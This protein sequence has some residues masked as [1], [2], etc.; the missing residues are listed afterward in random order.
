MVRAAKYEHGRVTELMVD[1]HYGFI[2]QPKGPLDSQ[3][4]WVW[5]CPS[6][7][8]VLSAS[9]PR[10]IVAHRFYVESL[11]ARG[12]CVGG[13]DV[14]ISCG[15]PAAVKVCT[16]FYQAVM[17][18]Y[19]L[20][21]RVRMIGQ[22]NGGLIAYAWAFRHP[23]SVDRILGIY[24][25]T[26]MR[27]WPG[28]DRVDPQTE[29]TAPD[30]SWHI[31]VPELR[32]RLKEFNPIDNLKP[33]AEA[34]VVLLHLHGD[35]DRGVPMGP[36][37]EEVV[38]RYQAMGGEAGLIVFEGRGHGPTGGPQFHDEVF[39]NS[40]RA[41]QFLLDLCCRF[42]SRPADPGRHLR[43]FVKPSIHKPCSRFPQ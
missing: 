42:E 27:T 14:G 38:K 10:G 7:Y 4:R 26:D 39:Y 5:D 22:S 16:D 43:V 33:L 35:S 8:A 20:N 15:S 34:G 12:F 37:S 9:P 24:P 11:L 41:L 17:S 2:I 1:G 25:V 18:K 40:E 21:Q 3:R 19:H 6:W 31:T 23:G 28:L 29:E 36:N 30:L 32:I 13:V